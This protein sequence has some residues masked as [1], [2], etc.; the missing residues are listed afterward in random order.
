MQD[1]GHAAESLAAQLGAPLAEPIRWKGVA[2]LDYY[3]GDWTAE[4]IDAGLAGAP[5]ESIEAENLLVNSGI[6]LL[7]DLLI[8]AGGT[9]FANAN[10]YIG[11]GD[12]STAAAA[13]QTDLQAATNRFKRVMD[14]TFPSRAG[15]TLTFR[16]TFSTSE[17]NYAI[18]E[19]GVFNGGPAFATGTMLN[20]VVSSLGTK[21][22]ATTLQV[23]V[24]VTIS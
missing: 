17:S 24:T 11:T 9:A 14:A 23:T 4:Q 22:S 12:S 20:R 7:L 2:R 8:G 13:G 10:T 16:T 3:D 5:V 21:T 15:Q 19:V 6:A 18:Q 1:M